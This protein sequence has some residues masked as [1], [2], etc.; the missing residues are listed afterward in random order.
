DVRIRVDANEGYGSVSE[1]IDVTRRQEAYDIFLCEQ[2]VSGYIGLAR[3]AARVNTP[4]MADESAWTVQDIYELDRLEAA[5]V[6]SCYV[7]KPGGLFRARQ[8]AEA[9][10]S[11]G[12]TYDIGGSIE[13][14][15][16]NAANLQLGVALSGGILPSVC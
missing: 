12:M 16:G 10:D 13:T 9:A 3:V 8:Q 4:V 7:T 6:F 14:G 2:P 11:L 15:I 1:A 5:S